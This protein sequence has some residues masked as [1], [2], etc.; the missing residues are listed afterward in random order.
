MAQAAT[1]T[2]QSSCYRYAH[3]T[4]HNIC[5]A[6]ALNFV[7]NILLPD[8]PT[9]RAQNSGKAPNRSR[10]RDT[11]KRTLASPRHTFAVETMRCGWLL[12]RSW[13][14]LVLLGLGLYAAVH[15]SPF[16]PHK[17]SRYP[18][19][20]QGWYL[21]VTTNHQDINRTEPRSFGIVIGSSQPESAA[22]GDTT[23]VA[24]LVQ[25]ADSAHQ[26]LRIDHETSVQRLNITR[27]GCPLVEEPPFSSSP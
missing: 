6:P 5:D 13:A 4:I 12:M 10:R 1:L 8:S 7:W 17:P 3:K 27:A 11:S 2:M 14:A 26:G 25:G 24:L 15:A 22:H 21:R 20:F 23:L 18:P 9:W 16:E 19:W